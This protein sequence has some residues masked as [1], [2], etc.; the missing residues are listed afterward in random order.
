MSHATIA[1]VTRS[2]FK[3]FTFPENQCYCSTLS[4]D[5]K[6]K[7]EEIEFPKGSPHYK[8]EQVLQP[9]GSSQTHRKYGACIS[10]QLTKFSINAMVY[11]LEQTKK[12][13]TA[14]V[15]ESRKVE[16]KVRRPK[17]NKKRKSSP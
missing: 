4:A 14:K 9:Y 13:S 3:G 2:R 10:C 1:E 17:T 7:C 12:S 8:I 6:K 5:E 11:Q 16:Q 15:S